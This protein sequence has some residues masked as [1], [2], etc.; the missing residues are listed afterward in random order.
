[1]DGSAGD[2]ARTALISQAG[3]SFE[4]YVLSREISGGKQ[5]ANS[6]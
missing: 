3:R 1:M 4:I 6:G 5:S 2:F